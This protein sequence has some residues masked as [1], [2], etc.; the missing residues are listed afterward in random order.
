MLTSAMLLENK[1]SFLRPGLNS[2]C[3]S[4][5]FQKHGS[6]WNHVTE[7][8]IVLLLLQGSDRLPCGQKHLLA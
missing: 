1:Q 7:L 2:S 6:T 5:A 3:I 4:V 8:L